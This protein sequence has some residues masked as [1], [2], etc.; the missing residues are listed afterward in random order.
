MVQMKVG[1]QLV[2]LPRSQKARRKLP[3]K[4]K[5]NKKKSSTTLYFVLPCMYFKP[6]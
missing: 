3:V 1:Y 2:M 4:F 6:F 5:K